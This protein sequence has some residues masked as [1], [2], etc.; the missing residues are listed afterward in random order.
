MRGTFYGEQV[1]LTERFSGRREV[2]DSYFLTSLWL[3]FDQS[4][5]LTVYTRFDNLFD[6]NYETAFDRRGIG[7]T[8]SVGIQISN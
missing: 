2:L 7:L 3:S 8:G 6:Q 4:N 5:R 1:V